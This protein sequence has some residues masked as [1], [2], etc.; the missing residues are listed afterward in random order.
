MGITSNDIAAQRA[1]LARG[2]EKR[3][4]DWKQAERERLRDTFAAAALTGLL[5][6]DYFSLG[7]EAAKRCYDIADAMLRERERH[8][9]PDA[10]KMVENT[11]NHDAVPEAKARTDPSES[12]VPLGNG[13][14]C[15]G[16]DKPVTLPAV[17]TGN[18]TLDGAPAAEAGAG[19]PQ[20]SHPQAGNTQTAP[21]CVETD[22]PPSKGEGF[23]IPDSRTRLSEAEIDALEYVVEEGRTASID[24]YGILRSWLIR[25]RPEWEHQSYEESDEKRVN[26]NTNRDATPGDGSVRG[27]GTVGER[28]VGRLSITQAML[29]DSEKLR[30]EVA[31]LREAIRLLA[32]H[33]ATLSVSGG[34]VTVTIDATLTDAERQALEFAVETGR[35]ATHDTAILRTLLERLS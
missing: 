30:A 15:G 11:T 35:V 12:S 29:E 31:N 26:T 24:D 17:G 20:I 16:T 2:E 5:S 32:D 3:K 7:D 4:A 9:I 10:G 28:L 14:G 1:M 34:N 22:G 8:H 19:K 13:G 33:D 21:P 27:E 18:T 23:H 25:M 6:N